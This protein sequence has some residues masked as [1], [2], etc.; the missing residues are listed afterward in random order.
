MRPSSSAKSGDRRA[1]TVIRSAATSSA[2]RLTYSDSAS[3]ADRS[4]TR[5]RR[6]GSAIT[7]PSRCRSR[8]ASRIGVRPAPSDSPSA[9]CVVTSPAAMS[10]LRIASRRR[11]WMFAT[12]WPSR[13][14]TRLRAAGIAEEAS[15]CI[16]SVEW[17]HMRG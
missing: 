3:S 10:P 16:G 15:S 14:T 1:G 8:S 4:A 2:I 9:T 6:L 13:E 7:R 17:I 5:T 11:A 12:F